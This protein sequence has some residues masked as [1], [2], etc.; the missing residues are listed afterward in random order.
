MAG[1]AHVADHP[2][3]P[4]LIVFPVGLWVFSFVCDLIYYFGADNTLWNDVAYRAMAGGIIGA[5]LAAIPG[6]IDYLSLSGRTRSIAA[7]HMGL[8]LLL[9]VLF[10]VNLYVRSQGIAVES[11]PIFLSFVGIVILGI[12]G[13]LGGSLVYVHATAV[14][15]APPA[16]QTP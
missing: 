5:L 7:V 3:H 15:C 1:P 4:M 9:V 11:A 10:A 6:F 2:I 14:E 12:S 16:E 8:N 13:W